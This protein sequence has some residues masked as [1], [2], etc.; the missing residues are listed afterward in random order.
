MEVWRNPN[1]HFLFLQALS[2]RRYDI[3]MKRESIQ[4]E[5]IFKAVDIST[6]F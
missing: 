4:Q 5:N 3:S 2:F 6:S 1:F